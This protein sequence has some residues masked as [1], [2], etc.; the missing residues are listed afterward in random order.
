MKRHRF[1]MHCVPFIQCCTGTKQVLQIANPTLFQGEGG[2]IKEVRGKMCPRYP[3]I[4]AL[5]QSASYTEIRTN[6]AVREL[7]LQKKY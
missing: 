5:G 7:E 4:V 3:L 6:T 2:N 1:C